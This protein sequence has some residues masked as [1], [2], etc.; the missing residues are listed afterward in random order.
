MHFTPTMRQLSPSVTQLSLAAILTPLTI[1]LV[2]MAALMSS[3]GQEIA[4]YIAIVPFGIVTS[5]SLESPFF[6]ISLTVGLLFFL[7][8]SLIRSFFS[9]KFFL[10]VSLIACY[11]IAIPLMDGL[12]GYLF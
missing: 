6:F 9:K 5:L 2:L 1:F 8:F 3:F 10:P 12:Y 11:L 4:Y 7:H